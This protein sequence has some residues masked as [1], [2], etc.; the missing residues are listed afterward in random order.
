MAGLGSRFSD[1][2][3]K[4]PKPLIPVSNKPMIIK[5]I[6]A[7]PKSDKWIF[8]V[9]KEHIDEH[10][11]DEIIKKE[12]PNAIIVSVEKTT[13]GQACTCL[14]AE[15]YLD[16]DEP[17]LIAACDNSSI[18]NK[19]KYEK[20]CNNEDI[21]SIIWTFTKSEKLN[22]KPEA[23][24]WCKLRDDNLTIE[25]MSVK[26]SISTNPFNDHAIVATFFFK[27]ARDFIDATKLMI[28]ENYRINNEF[29][30]DAIPIFLNKL[31]KRSVIFDIDLHICW[32]TPEDLQNYEKIEQFCTQN[33]STELSEEDKN[34]I[35]LW[36]KYFNT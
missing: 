11:I 34:N 29:Y 17:I 24:G 14:L 27:K 30:V 10:K 21:D 31:G 26:K 22:I 32:G 36:K 9:R 15:P 28:K 23:Y 16:Q 18:Y 3:Y 7:L 12:I 20:L 25:N 4:I 1:E 33:E 19:E 35:S 5:V 13:E 6:E 2:G 8:I